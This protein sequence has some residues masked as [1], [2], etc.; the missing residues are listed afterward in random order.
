[1]LTGCF[2]AGAYRKLTSLK[3]NYPHLKVLL[4]MGGGEVEV[5]EDYSAVAK[6]PSRLKA[7]ITSV[8]EFLR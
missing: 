6:S 1:M 2:N 5:A 3:T 8:L 4:I 7:V